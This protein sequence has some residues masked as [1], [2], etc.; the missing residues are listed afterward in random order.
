MV[1]DV[2][3][4]VLRSHALH[5]VEPRALLGE[6]HVSNVGITVHQ[7]QP[8]RGPVASHR[9]KL[10]QQQLVRLSDVPLHELG[11]PPPHLFQRLQRNK[12]PERRTH[13]PAGGRDGPSTGPPVAP[14]SLRGGLPESGM[15][16][17]E[18][19]ERLGEAGA[20]VRVDHGGKLGLA[21]SKVLEDE[22]EGVALHGHVLAL[23]EETLGHLG[24]RA[25]VGVEVE[26]IVVHPEH[27]EE[28]PFGQPPRR[29]LYKHSVLLSILV[30]KI[31]PRPRGA[32]SPR[33]QVGDLPGHVLFHRLLAP[34]P[35]NLPPEKARQ[36][37]R[38]Y[39]TNRPGYASCTVQLVP[40]HSTEHR[41]ELHRE[42]SKLPQQRQQRSHL[43]LVLCPKSPEIRGQPKKYRNC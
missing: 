9:V 37:R 30:H 11:V 14:D 23:R 12:L 35:N 19:G 24:V 16:L 2:A 36:H 18:G 33:P 27:G 32:R 22:A 1:R 7:G 28:Q 25:D 34:H 31:Q 3:H 6:E 4:G 5:V 17:G 39:V 20:G 41:D 15:E 8:P 38:C 26:L 29:H 42:H 13:L 21:L 10:P 40:Q 43:L